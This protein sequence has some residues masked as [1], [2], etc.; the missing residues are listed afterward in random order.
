MLSTQLILL[1]IWFLFFLVDH[2]SRLKLRGLRDTE[3]VRK[4]EQRLSSRLEANI[5]QKW[6]PKV[7]KC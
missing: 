1:Q 2:G 6:L 3:G 7:Q 5:I 4:T